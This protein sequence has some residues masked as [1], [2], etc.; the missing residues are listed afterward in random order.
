MKAAQVSHSRQKYTI[1][2]N[3]GEGQK[4]DMNVKAFGSLLVQAD[5]TGY[6]LVFSNRSPY[7]E[8][9]YVKGIFYESTTKSGTVFLVLTTRGRVPQMRV[10]KLTG[11]AFNKLRA[12]SSD[13]SMP[14][15]S[16]DADPI[17]ANF[18]LEF[19]RVPKVTGGRNSE[20]RSTRLR[21]QVY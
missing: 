3:E 2:F 5:T 7:G 15:K 18:L 8:D 11:A 20:H 12:P 13:E 10:V 9:E 1:Y 16:N 4:V 17:G 14:R 21:E 19:L 6:A